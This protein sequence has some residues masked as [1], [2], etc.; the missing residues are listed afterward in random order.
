MKK[1][2]SAT[3]TITVTRAIPQEA[4]LASA[5]HIMAR[6]QNVTPYRNPP[7]EH[8]C[9][10]RSSSV[11]FAKRVGICITVNRSH[12]VTPEL[13]SAGNRPGHSKGNYLQAT[14]QSKFK[15]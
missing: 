3:A 7:N 15:F 13:N 11:P 2:G 12:D 8:S 10:P 6:L 14:D 5:K 4:P 1:A 9:T